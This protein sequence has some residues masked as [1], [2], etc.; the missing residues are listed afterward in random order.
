M[1]LVVIC[2]QGRHAAPRPTCGVTHA[3]ALSG[4][5]ETPS[6]LPEQSVVLRGFGDCKEE[7]VSGFCFLLPPSRS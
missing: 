4:R 3:N 6:H 7:V 2:G 1:E 5:T